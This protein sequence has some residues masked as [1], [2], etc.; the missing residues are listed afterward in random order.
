MG[1]NTKERILEESLKLFSRNGY[2]GT[3]MSDIAKQLGITKGALYRHYASKQE[4]FDSIL[5]RMEQ[6]DYER[7][8]E[9]EVPEGT[10]EEME[11]AYEMA[12]IE[13]VVTY[14]KAQFLYWTEDEFASS[15]RKMLMLEQ[16][17]DEEMAKLYQNYIGE[18][19]LNYMADLFGSMLEKEEEAMQTALDFYGPVFLLYSVYDGA[20]DK[21]AVIAMLDH[22]LEQF[23]A[24]VF[25]EGKCVK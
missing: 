18:G 14:T 9:Y 24:S 23:A 2:L 17:R 12:S 20:A 4:I 16:Y 15:F 1:K 11:E 21:E 25:E 7:A 22:H 5:R 10:I 3:S 6:M 19:P 13:N 8:R